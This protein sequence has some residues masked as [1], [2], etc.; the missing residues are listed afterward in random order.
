MSPKINLQ[1]ALTLRTF[2]WGVLPGRHTSHLPCLLL[3]FS[4]HL[5]KHSKT[6]IAQTSTWKSHQGTLWDPRSPQENPFPGWTRCVHLWLSWLKIERWCCSGHLRQNNCP[7]LPPR[8]HPS[9]PRLRAV[10]CNSA[11]TAGLADQREP[12]EIPSPNP[13]PFTTLAKLSQWIK[14]CF[15]FFFCYQRSTQH[16]GKPKQLSRREDKKNKMSILKSEGHRVTCFQA[17]TLSDTHDPL[18]M[19]SKWVFLLCYH[20]PVNSLL[21]P[22][23][24]VAVLRVSDEEQF[25]VEGQSEV[26]IGGDTW[27][28][29]ENALW[30]N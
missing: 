8:G 25:S 17:M 21:L 10:V 7:D 22:P 5:S 19:F 3:S 28:Q 11:H 4:L 16:V 20:C 14:F 12:G 30:I 2:V 27:C 23:V 24:P 6:F 29:A 15:S 9:P 13:R 18:D 26:D 1:S